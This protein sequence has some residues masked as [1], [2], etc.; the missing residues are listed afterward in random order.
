MSVIA[1]RVRA[2]SGWLYVLPALILV[3]VFVYYPVVENFRLSTFQWNAFSTHPR[4]VGLGNYAG[5]MADPVF[6]R[7]IF[8]N[9][10]YAIVSVIWQVGFGLV[11]AAILEETVRARLRAFL[12]TVY[13][14][15]VTISIT[16]TGLLFQ[17]LYHPQFGLVNR[18]LVILGHPQWTHSWLGEEATAIWAI[19]GMSQW[20]SV[21]YVMVLLTVAMQKIPREF[22]EAAYIDGTTKVQAFF[23]ITVPLLREMTTLMMILTISG[24]F[25][26]FNEVKVMTDGGPNNASQVL[27]TWLYRSAFQNDQMGYASAIATVIFILTFGAGV[28]QLWGVRGKQVEF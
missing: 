17:F 5:L 16:V 21:G 9:I 25:L 10:A 13:F 22:Y 20:Q 23:L 24:A 19:I 14:I 12:R 8:N 6:W 4:Y 2:L 26:V 11:L 15:P 3:A 28:A 27:G 7:A 1:K 18:V